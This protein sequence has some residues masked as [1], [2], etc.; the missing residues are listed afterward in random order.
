MPELELIYTIMTILFMLVF[1]L[2]AIFMIITMLRAIR[3]PKA[4]YPP[5]ARELVGQLM[6]PKCGSK[7]LEPIGYYTLRCKDCGF[8]FRIGAE[9]H[10]G[11]YFW[12]WII[13]PLMWPI[14]FWSA[15]REK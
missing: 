14:L 12:P 2:V 11:V 6:C 5:P 13:P 10:G 9:R 1:L 4:Y 7:E 8:T 3:A 15:S